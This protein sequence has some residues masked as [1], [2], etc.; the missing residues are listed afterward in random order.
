MKESSNN[1]Y[2]YLIR[3]QQGALYTGIT[4]DVKR[5]FAEHCAQGP[6]CAKSLRGK[7]P[8]ELVLKQFIGERT[9]ALKLEH[10]IKK[11]DKQQ[12]EHLIKHKSLLQL[13]LI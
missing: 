4:T 11:L 5:R 3:T 8:F 10:R 9:D 6:K 13:G 2:I 7:G 1:W 12:K